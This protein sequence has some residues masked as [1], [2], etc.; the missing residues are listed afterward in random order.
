MT[1]TRATLCA[2]D[3]YIMFKGQRPVFTTNE[4]EALV[5]WLWGRDLRDHYTVLDYEK[6][7][8]VD[9]PDLD[10]WI[11]RFEENGNVEPE[12]PSRVPLSWPLPAAYLCL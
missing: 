6:A 7:Y 8:G 12:R 1:E 9:N 3:R 5:A 4:K 11:Q 10:T 2:T